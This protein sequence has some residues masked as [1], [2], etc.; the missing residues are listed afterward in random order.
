LPD[1]NTVIS[2]EVGETESEVVGELMRLYNDSDKLK[3]F[4]T[5]P[6]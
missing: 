6:D 1:R 3:E 5:T 2:I 4:R